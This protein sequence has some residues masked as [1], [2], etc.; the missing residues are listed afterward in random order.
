[1][2]L[3][4]QFKESIRDHWEIERPEKEPVMNLT[5]AM[6]GAKDFDLA[7]TIWWLQKHPIDHINWRVENSH[8]HDIEKLPMNFR[9][10][11]TNEVLSPAEVGV[12]KHNANRFDLDRRG[13]GSSAETPGDVW[14]LPYW[15]GRYLEVISAPLNK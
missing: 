2:S 15:M 5:Y 13:N 1:M 14:L 9:K 7:E 8:R 11:Y 3:K 12:S 6:T 10:Q 4:V